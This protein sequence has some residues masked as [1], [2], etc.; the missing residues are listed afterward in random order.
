MSEPDAPRT[1]RLVAVGAALLALVFT[2]IAVIVVLT[3]DGGPSQASAKADAP[4]ADHN[5]QATDVVRLQRNDVELVIAHG[6]TNGL[7][8][9]DA[10][11]AKSLGL[12]PDDVIVSLSGK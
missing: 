10:A 12:E 4:F 6:T 1:M 2:L 5:V 7:R 9:K 11:L 8:V 3:R